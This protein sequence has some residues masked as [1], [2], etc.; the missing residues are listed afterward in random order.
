MKKVPM[1]R[2]NTIY[3]HIGVHKTGTSSIQ[4]T[5]HCSANHAQLKKNGILIL[6][7]LPANHSEFIQSAFSDRPEL[8]H[9]NLSKNLSLIEVTKYANHQ[10]QQIVDHVDGHTNSTFIFSGE[11]AC[12][13]S[14]D[15]FIRLRNFIYEAFG[16]DALINII[17]YTRNPFSYVESAVQENVKGNRMT[18]AEAAS[19][20]IAES[21]C[22]YINIYEKLANAFG[23]N[24]INFYSFENC[25]SNETGVVGSFLSTLGISSDGLHILNSNEGITSDSVKLISIANSAGINITHTDIRIMS[26]IKGKKGGFLTTEDINKIQINSSSDRLFLKETFGIEYQDIEIISNNKIDI[27]PTNDFLKCISAQGDD[28]TKELMELVNNL[29]KK[30]D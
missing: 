23:K 26:S 16:N 5:L 27:N 7:S 15:G 20:H 30:S 19:W 9:T 3:V 2:S 12:I 14:L 6:S 28:I 1:K 17:C 18:I 10:K 21:K 4:S 29:I 8:Y 11:D 13:L 25:L 24:A 22:K